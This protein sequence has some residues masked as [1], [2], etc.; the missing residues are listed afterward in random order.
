MGN[1]IQK[2]KFC[3]NVCPKAFSKNGTS[4]HLRA[5]GF[6]VRKDILSML[7]RGLPAI[8]SGF[9]KVPREYPALP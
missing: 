1:I 2:Q 5:N 7:P 4:N 9:P 8:A 6:T 3:F